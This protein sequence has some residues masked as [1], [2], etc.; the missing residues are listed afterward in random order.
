MR[1]RL[2]R[3]EMAKT[4]NRTETTGLSDSELLILDK[5]AM[6]GGL[7]SMYFNDVFPLQF[8][9]PEHGLDD[10]SLVS[11]LNR[12][13]SNGILTGRSIKTRHGRPDRTIRVTEHGGSVWESER[14]PDWTR[15]VTEYYGSSR[16]NS[17]RHRVTIL[18]H[19]PVICRS[20]FNVGIQCGFLD[21]R[22]GPMATGTGMRNLVYWR[23]NQNVFM[24]SAW[25]ESLHSTTDWDDFE[26]KRTW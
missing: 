13:E 22:N 5:V 11:T 8:N 12:L 23:P 10:D 1:L 17:Q 26:T 3:Y 20:F 14:K 19:S 7:R 18:G 24:L 6:L 2:V 16:P 21:Y 25:V 15:Y 9:C 4:I